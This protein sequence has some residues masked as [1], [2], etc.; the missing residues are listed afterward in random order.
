MTNVEV[1]NNRKPTYEIN[2][3][4]LNR[5]SPRSFLPEDISDPTKARLVAQCDVKNGIGRII[6]FEFDEALGFSVP[7]EKV[8]G[9]DKGLQHTFNIKNDLFAT[10]ANTT[11]V[12]FKKYYL[13]QIKNMIVFLK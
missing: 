1:G 8:D 10:T 6:N 12:N 9:A 11:L 4:I 5:W 7:V 2:P 13:K 3:L